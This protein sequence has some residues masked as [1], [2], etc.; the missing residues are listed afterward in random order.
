MVNIPAPVYGSDF[1][2][3]APYEYVRLAGGA[4]LCSLSAIFRARACIYIWAIMAPGNCDSR[5]SFELLPYTWQR[6]FQRFL[7]SLLLLVATSLLALDGASAATPPSPVPQSPPAQMLTSPLLLRSPLPQPRIAA[8]VLSIYIQGKL[9]YRTTKPIGSWLLTS[10]NGSRSSYMLPNQPVDILSGEEIP[11]GRGVLLTCFLPNTSTTTCSKI[12]NARITQA[13]MPAAQSTNITLRVLVMVV[14]LS[15]SS[16][17]KSRGGANVTQ[18]QNAFL[19]PNGYA[20][21]FRNCSYD[22]MVFDRK[23]FMVM[24]TVIPCSTTIIADCNVDAIVNNAAEFQLLAGIEAETYTHSVYILPDGLARTCNWMGLAVIPGTKTWFMPDMFL[25]IHELNNA[26]DN[27]IFTEGDPKVSFI[28]A[29]DPGSSVTIFNYKLHLLVG[30][31]DSKTSTII[32]TLCRFVTGLNECTADAPPSPPKSSTRLTSPSN[33]PISMPP[34]PWTPSLSP[35]NPPSPMLPSPWGPPF[36]PK[37]PTPLP[38]LTPPNISPS[39]T[40]T[41]A[42]SS[43]SG[44]QAPPPTHSR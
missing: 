29:Y 6:R 17:C 35:P 42:T 16:E 11:P 12:T 20:D 39:T 31:F 2:W 7:L 33:P 13:A 15:N 41:S 30:V 40:I 24:P 9:L 36:K 10:I 23:N 14:S 37:S 1:H 18:V 21:F 26:I 3:W 38:P 8:S 4:S 22:M 44:T 32:V 34:S 28:G 5:W 27:G 43:A 25:N 19:G